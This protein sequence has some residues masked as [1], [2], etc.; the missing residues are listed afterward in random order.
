MSACVTAGERYMGKTGP[1][2][3]PAEIVVRLP[4]RAFVADIA[5]VPASEKQMAVI[6]KVL[7]IAANEPL[8]PVSSLAAGRLIDRVTVG[9]A[10]GRG[11]GAFPRIRGTFRMLVAGETNIQRQSNYSVKV[12]IVEVSSAL[13]LKKSSFLRTTDFANTP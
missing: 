7:E 11:I 9:K 4:K 12:G 3:F 5:P 10:V 2:Y 8:P 1:L 13:H 6:R